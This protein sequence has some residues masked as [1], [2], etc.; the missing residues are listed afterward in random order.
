[1]SDAYVDFDELAEKIREWDLARALGIE[2]HGR[3][4]RCPFP[5]HHENGDRDPS[6]AIYRYEGRLYAKCHTSGKADTPVSLAAKVWGCGHREA[7]L[8]LAQKAGL[9]H[10]I[11]RPQPNGDSGERPEIYTYRDED[12]EPVFRVLRFS[13]KQFAQQGR[14]GESWKNGMD[15]VRRVPYRLPEVLEAV[16]DGDLVYI[17]EGE[18]D[19]HAV[20][21]EGDVAT[22]NPGGAGKWREEF[23]EHFEEGEIRVVADDDRAGRDHARRVARSLMDV[24]ENVE[25]LKP[26]DGNDV[27][28]HLDA[29]YALDELTQ[30]GG[31]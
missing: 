8:R 22:C 30:L 4:W 25:L 29:G 21:D 31:S 6:F 11:Q 17:V 15:G 26:A 23:N 20:E 12:G 24:A 19:V 3:A 28:D 16:E 2:R 1:M 14:Q 13:G 27:E 10:L 18:R 7:A 9:G 5:E